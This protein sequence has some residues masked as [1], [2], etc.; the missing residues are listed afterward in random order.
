MHR[1]LIALLI[2]FLLASCTTSSPYNRGS[3]SDAMEKARDDYPDD[4][5][6]ETERD[7]KPWWHD[8]SDDEEIASDDEYAGDTSSG[9]VSADTGPVYLGLRGGNAWRSSPYFDS[10]FDIEMLLGYREDAV[11]VLLFGGI[12]AVEAKETSDIAESID[13]GVLFLRAGLEAR[14]Y[15]F[16]QLTFLSPYVLGQVGG[17]YMY[18][19]FKN[20]IDAGTETIFGDAVGGMILAAGVGVN[21][22][23]TDSF[24][25]GAVCIPETH[26]FTS[27]T[28]KGFQND[29]FDYYGTVRWAVEAGI[30]M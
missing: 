26:L 9:Y 20:P 15:P 13:S 27:E 28:H 24:R 5:E 23:D 21:L 18:W 1:F 14:Y 7:K 10:L 8:D 25:L 19:S 4:R 29:V 2:L 30:V 12:K 17:L 22:I 3:L 16:P 11:E 6:V